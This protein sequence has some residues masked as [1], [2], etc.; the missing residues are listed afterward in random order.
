MGIEL[1][2]PVISPCLKNSVDAQWKTDEY[3]ILLNIKEQE[4]S[5]YYG[6]SIDKTATGYWEIEGTL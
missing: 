2:T 3:K 4:P 6:A 1:G 5:S